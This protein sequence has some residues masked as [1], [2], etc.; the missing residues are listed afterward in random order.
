MRDLWIEK[1]KSGESCGDSLIHSFWSYGS[2]GPPIPELFTGRLFY[3]V[4]PEMIGVS[5]DVI[6]KMEAEGRVQVAMYP[7]GVAHG[8][9][10]FSSTKDFEEAFGK[11]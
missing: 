8:H 1:P 7:N 4:A 3:D 5:W 10:K 6:G 9:L 2:G 11:I